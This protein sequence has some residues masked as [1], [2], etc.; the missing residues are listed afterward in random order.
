IAAILLAIFIAALIISHLISMILFVP[1]LLGLLALQ[2]LGQNQVSK[3][4][5]ILRSTWIL[6]ALFVGL[7]LSSWYWLPVV[8]ERSFIQF[9]SS[10]LT[11]IYIDHFVSWRDLFSLTREIDSSPY[12]LEVIQV[13]WLAVFAAVSSVLIFLKKFFVPEQTNLVIWFWASILFGSFFLITPQA[14]LL[15]SLIP[16]LDST[17]FP[18]RLLWI[19]QLAAVSILALIL[20]AQ[21]KLWQQVMA[22]II[23]ISTLWSVF[24][25]AQ[26]KGVTS[27][28]DYEWY[29]SVETGSSFDEFRPIWAKDN[30][31]LQDRIVFV[32][33][34]MSAEPKI[35]V[36]SWTGTKME[37]IVQTDQAGSVVQKT[38][39][40][41][42]WTVLINEEGQPINFHLPG[43]EGL[44]AY[45]IPA[46]STQVATSFSGST[47]ARNGGKIATV[48]GIVILGAV[49]AKPYLY[50][51]NA[52]SHANRISK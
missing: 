12:F 27:R 40:F 3:S 45:E 50:F 37:Y 48:L 46:G 39:Y 43:Y 20:V 52:N 5:L 26:P 42:G 47:A 32:A 44:I 24:A 9:G 15:W 30:Y 11:D 38:L 31:N 25:Y 23:L 36:Q 10:Q 41:P 1:I 7:L 28:V 13:G 19:S 51:F 4:Q 22:G 6:S 14:A 35:E 34:D 18:W 8:F 49:L 17:Q 2:L 16:G 33:D 29:E 21:N